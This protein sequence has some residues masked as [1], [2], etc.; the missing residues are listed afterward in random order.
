MQEFY[1]TTTS[2][3]FE[4]IDQVKDKVTEAHDHWISE[5]MPCL[6]ELAHKT[7]QAREVQSIRGKSENGKNIVLCNV[8]NYETC[9]LYILYICSFH[10]G[11]QCYLKITFS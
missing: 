7:G 8:S 4:T 3:K 9:M 5:L 6:M 10:K 11:T 2:E 1:L